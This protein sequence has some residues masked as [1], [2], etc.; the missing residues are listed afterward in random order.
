MESSTRKE[1]R[2]KIIDGQMD[3]WMDDGRMDKMK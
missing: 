3:G 2:G 1:E